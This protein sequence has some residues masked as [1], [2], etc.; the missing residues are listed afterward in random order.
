LS[1]TGFATPVTAGTPGTFTVT[2]FDGSGQVITG[3]R[4]TVHFTGSDPQAVFPADYTFTAADGG[5]TLITP[6]DQIL[7]ATDT[8]SGITSSAVVTVG[9]AAPVLSMESSDAVTPVAGGTPVAGKNAPGRF[10]LSAEAG[11]PKTS[12]VEMARTDAFDRV[13]SEGGHRPAHRVAAD[14]WT[15]DPL[16]Y[17]RPQD[18]P[19]T[20]SASERERPVL[21]SP[22]L[23]VG[24]GCLFPEFPKWGA[25]G[26]TAGHP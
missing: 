10:A 25:R 24:G 2:L 19:P 11:M 14:D 21:P 7:T 1:V 26:Q 22:A 17:G 15:I 3:Y 4:G 12:F 16:D 20:R 8:T 18:P 9:T 23:R 6:G 13:F 5:V